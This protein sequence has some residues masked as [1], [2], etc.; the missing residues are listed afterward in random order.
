[1]FV[2]P[3]TSNITATMAD[4]GLTFVIVWLMG[5]SFGTA[6]E[7][8]ALAGLFSAIVMSFGEYLFHFY[9]IKKDL[10][11]TKSKRLNTRTQ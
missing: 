5:M 11:L 6:A 9:L 4:L 3:K 1:M 10:G 7:E 2:L 8:A